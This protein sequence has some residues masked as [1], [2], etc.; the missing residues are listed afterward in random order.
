MVTYLILRFHAKFEC[1][2][3][4]ALKMFLQSIQ[5]R[6]HVIVIREITQ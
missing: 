4:N 5:H 6:V 2:F 3:V 1:Q